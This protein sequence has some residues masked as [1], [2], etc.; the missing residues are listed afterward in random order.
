MDEKPPEPTPPKPAP[1]RPQIS[2]PRSRSPRP[3][4]PEP[5]QSQ[6]PQPQDEAPP[7]EKPAPSSTPRSRSPHLPLADSALKAPEPQQQP[8]PAKA[9]EARKLFQTPPGKPEAKKPRQDQSPEG[10]RPLPTIEPTTPP[11]QHPDASSSHLP[12]PTAQPQADDPDDLDATI[13]YPE[14]TAPTA[15]HTD[16]LDATIEYPEQPGDDSQAMADLTI[17]YP[18]PLLSGDESFTF[19]AIDD[20]VPE[21]APTHELP[22]T[23]DQA[24]PALVFEGPFTRP[25]CFYYDFAEDRCYSVSSDNLIAEHELPEHWAKIDEADREEA[26]SFLKHKVF[27]LDRR[28]FANN[29]VDGTW[30]RRW[31]D[32]DKGII[33]SRCC[34][35]GFLDRQKNNIDRHSS[36]A[37]RLSH[38]LAVSLATT[39]HLEPEAFDISAAFLQGLRFSEIQA[40]ARELG[41]ECR[42][43]RKVWFRPPANIWRHFR[44]IPG[45]TIKVDDADIPTKILRCLKALYGLVDGP[46][47]WQLALLHFLKFD[48]GFEVSRHDENL[49]FI[50]R[51]GWLIAIVTV[52]VDD[53]LLAAA[54]GLRDKIANTLNHKFGKVK[55]NTLPFIYLGISHERCGEGLFLHQR[56]YLEKI[57]AAQLDNE[58]RASHP[59]SPLSTTE[60]RSFRSLVCS[61]LWVCQTRP[62]ICHGVVRLQTEMVTPHVEHLISANALLKKAKLNII[63]NGL[64]YR[65]LSLP[66][67]IACVSDC[68]HASKKSV[69][70][71][72]GKIVFIM[73]DRLPQQHGSEQ[74][75]TDGATTAFGGNAHLIYFSAK[76]AS[77]ISHSTSHAET[78]SAVGCTQVGHLVAQRLS[79]LF[80]PFVLTGSD[81]AAS[82]QELLDY[83]SRNLQI[84]PVDAYTDC[85]DLFELCTGTKGLSNDKSQRLAILALREDR[86]LGR[87]RW[88]IHTPTKAMVADGLTKDG[89]FQQ[90]LFLCTT[91]VFK[92][93]VDI[94]LR[95]RRATQPQHDNE[96]TQQQ[97][98]DHTE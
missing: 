86:L 46:L 7:R 53:L 21:A 61:L 37:S 2:S 79:E 12:R 24:H 42:T 4:Q 1:S 73:A 43:A 83:Q 5:Q 58:S 59:T 65:P 77:R 68:G 31:K 9:A 19:H 47:L 88:M 15:D 92:L 20:A 26:A 55:R 14:P 41:H 80:L 33:R 70:P 96:T 48:L 52:H 51:H 95:A 84:C 72:E 91:G 97:L 45:S 85:M 11:D 50:C 54:T 30:V 98:E 67:R 78:L 6:E 71:F 3:A 93:P 89:F 27:E 44:E 36:T 49:L 74:W 75:F 17:E 16:D 60:H 81:K 87:T 18:E 22:W 25:L 66:L 90:L 40:R 23:R 63:T 38:R 76:R 32:K 29:I 39:F 28:D 69:Y 56:Q 10:Q 94:Q 57:P 13:E 82:L 34:G 8:A 64:H 35:R 62:D